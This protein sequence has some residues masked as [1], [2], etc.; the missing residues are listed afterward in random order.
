MGKPIP[1]KKHKPARISPSSGVQAKAKKK[2]AKLPAVKMRH[3][4]WMI[5]GFDTSL[6]SIAGAAIA[7]DRILNKTRGPAF[8]MRR[9]GSEDHYYDRLEMCA[10]SH[11][12]IHDLQAELG[13]VGYSTDEIFIAQEEPFPM[14]M[15]KQMESNAIKQQ[16]E[17]SGA[18][19]GG[20]IRYG[21]RNVW[22]INSHKWRKLVAD[23]L[24]ITTHFSKWKD[25]SLAA[26]FNCRPDDT[27]KFRAKQWAVNPGH[28]FMGGAFPEEVPVWPDII[29]SK[30][31]KIPRPEGST[32]KAL[33][34][35]DRYDALA[36]MLWLYEELSG[37]GTLK[38]LAGRA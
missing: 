1:Q 2:K 24:G 34:P 8:L 19:L 3:H 22:Q 9:W 32:A 6:S 25:A 31:M 30:G 20:L 38:A 10:R 33:Q 27:G 35:D 11:E 23:D 36:I 7:Y 37:D 13:C 26:E 29:V 17:I 12:F 4:G 14:G 18:L 5:A 21:F 16:A 28:S 15:V